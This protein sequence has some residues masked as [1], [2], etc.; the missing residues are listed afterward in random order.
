MH[1]ECNAADTDRPRGERA[2]KRS[3]LRRPDPRRR[4]LE[5][6]QQPD[7]DDDDRQ[8]AAAGSRPDD[9]AFHRDTACESDPDRR[10]EGRPVRHAPLHELEGDVRGEHRHPALREVDHL[11]RAIDQHECNRETRVHATLRK[12]G[13][14]LLGE[15]RA[16]QRADREE[17]A[18]HQE[19]QRNRPRDGSLVSICGA[20]PLNLVG[21]IVTG[22]RVPNLVNARVLYRDGAPIATLVAGEF[23]A[24]EPMDEAAQWAAKKRLLQ[25]APET[26]APVLSA[27]EPE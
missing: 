24:L 7:R 4:A 16:R 25:G 19:E 10:R 8:H 27:V 1:G 23:T 14:G 15:D 6:Q 18:R 11:G 9:H 2:A 20:D 21:H 12:A 26:E 22:E 13:N 17:H 5:Q 3:D